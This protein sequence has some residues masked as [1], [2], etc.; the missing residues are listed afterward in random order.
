MDFKKLIDNITPE[1]YQALRRAIEIG[2]WPNG[3]VLTAEQREHCMSAVIAWDSRHQP[4]QD[5]VGYIDKGSKEEG[6]LCD[7]DHSHDNDPESDQPL[8]WMH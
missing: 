7:D 2:K 5:R 6:E 8:R 1:I 3:D 4:E